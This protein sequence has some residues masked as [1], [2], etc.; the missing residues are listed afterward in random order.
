M[1]GISYSGADLKIDNKLITM[2][3]KILE[4][5]KSGEVI[6]VFLDP[7][8]NLGKT[9]QYRNLLAY[10]ANATKKWEAELPTSKISDVYWKI[11]NK[12]PL[13]AYSFSSYECEIDISTGK[14]LKKSF[15]K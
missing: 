8:A 1:S 3:Y 10:D 12:T 4:V 7:D 6:V 9:G 13:V 15:Y 14:I 11:V 2:P 5:F